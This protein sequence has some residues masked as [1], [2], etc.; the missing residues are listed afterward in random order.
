MFW[1]YFENVACLVAVFQF[2][3]IG[4][5]VLAQQHSANYTASTQKLNGKQKKKQN[6]S[7]SKK[8]A[9]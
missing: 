5:F 4:I 1:C 8:M 7:Y 6:R 9:I 3:S 2:S